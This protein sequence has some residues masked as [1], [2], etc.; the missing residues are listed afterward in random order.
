MPALP[1]AKDSNDDDSAWVTKSGSIN[2]SLKT[3][4]Q[5]LSRGSAVG[6]RAGITTLPSSSSTHSLRVSPKVAKVWVKRVKG[7]LGSTPKTAR[8]FPAKLLSG[9]LRLAT[10]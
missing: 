3:C 5:K 6:S 4:L 9:S 8:P 1:E 10:Y 2:P 7:A